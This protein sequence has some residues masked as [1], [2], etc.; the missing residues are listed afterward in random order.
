[1]TADYPASRSPYGSRRL[2]HYP[3]LLLVQLRSHD[4]RRLPLRSDAV[5]ICVERGCTWS[6]CCV[7]AGLDV[8]PRLG[9]AASTRLSFLGAVGIRVGEAP[10]LGHPSLWCTA[11]AA[12]APRS[13]P[14]PRPPGPSRRRG[15]AAHRPRR[16]RDRRACVYAASRR[17][18]SSPTSPRRPASTPTYPRARRRACLRTAARRWG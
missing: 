2:G 10:A 14:W 1:M 17:R 13:Q 12:A 5:C 9:A 8:T 7:L 15:E 6:G 16:L 4:L 18:R 11:L 3:R